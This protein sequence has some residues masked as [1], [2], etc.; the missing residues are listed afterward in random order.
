MTWAVTKAN[1]I[2]DGIS[3]DFEDQSNAAAIHMEM[4]VVKA[5][6]EIRNNTIDDCIKALGGKY[7][8]SAIAALKELKEEA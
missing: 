1:A 2:I 4:T 6:R 3:E 7:G 8:A 5:L